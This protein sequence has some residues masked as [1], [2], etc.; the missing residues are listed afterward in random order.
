VN[1]DRLIDLLSAN[2]E[3]VVRVQFGKKLFLAVLTGGAA[4]LVLMLATVGP[5]AD[6]D[7]TARLGWTAVKLLFAVSV[8]GSATPLLL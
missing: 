6:L 2:L 4:A 5:R 8:I 3:P 7:S 1:T